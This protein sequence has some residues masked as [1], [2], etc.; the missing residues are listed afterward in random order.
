[1]KCRL[2]VHVIVGL[3]VGGAEL[4]LLRLIGTQSTMQVGLRHR[5][6]SLT[7]IGPVGLQLQQLGIVVESLDMRSMIDAPQALWRL[8]RRLRSLKPDVVQ[9]WMYHA[10]F[11]GGIAAQLA[12]IRNVFWRVCTTDVTKGGSQT[13]VLLRWLCAQLSRVVPHAILCVAHE[14]RRV[15]LAVGYCPTKTTVLT[16]GFDMRRLFVAPETVADFRIHCGLREGERVVGTV[17]RFNAVK[18]QRNFV[19]AASILARQHPSVRFL[20]V[21]RGCEWENQELAGWITETGVAGRFV[22]LGHRDD[23]PV[24]LAAM[25]VFALTS[26]TEGFPNVLGEAM[27]M[28]RPCV[29][30]NVG[31]AAYL[32]DGLGPVVEPGDPHALAEG[33]AK[34]LEMPE[35]DVV[36]LG[37]K[38]RAR[39]ER[40]FS[41]EQCAQRF[42]DLY[43]NAMNSAGK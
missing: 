41:M 15:H 22:L 3:N 34:M 18:D 8:T 26:R 20:M 2:V 42:A 1:M 10:D 37:V 27:A 19:Q 35:V 13:T 31:D 38:Q 25:D 17:G 12:G 39:I 30:T 6:I 21:G 5:V 36:A 9:T 24:C 11:L 40:D 23:A 29:T 43:A 33:I 4:M 7:E 28:G 32:L 16:N 14:A